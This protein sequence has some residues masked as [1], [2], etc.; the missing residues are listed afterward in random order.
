MANSNSNFDLQIFFT[1]ELELNL[2]RIEFS[3]LMQTQLVLKRKVE[4]NKQSKLKIKTCQK[5]SIVST[6]FNTLFYSSFSPRN[7]L[8]ILVKPI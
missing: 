6:D 4:K 3:S 5:A 7:L 2:K 1:L 8:D